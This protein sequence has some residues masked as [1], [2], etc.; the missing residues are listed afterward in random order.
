MEL[1]VTGLAYLLWWAYRADQD[2]IRRH[3]EPMDRRID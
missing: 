3:V 1:Y 2:F